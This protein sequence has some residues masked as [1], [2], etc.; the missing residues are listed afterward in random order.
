MCSSAGFVK[1][2]FWLGCRGCIQS[3]H[4]AGFGKFSFKNW[5]RQSPQ[6]FLAVLELSAIETQFR[7]WSLFW[8]RCCTWAVVCSPCFRQRVNQLHSLLDFLSLPWSW[9][10]YWS[11]SLQDFHWIA[12]LFR[13]SKPI[14]P[15]AFWKAINVRSFNVIE[16][17][18]V[19]DCFGW[20][21]RCY[22][23]DSS[24]IVLH[25]ASSRPCVFSDSLSSSIGSPQNIPLIMLFESSKI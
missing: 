12:C 10:L 25:Q 19:V 8:Y 18:W 6:S 11:A 4:S 1:V 15:L 23:F 22:Y 21:L 3:F 2:Y 14:D 24:K 9:H 17:V 7:C 20:K 5:V 13:A 16:G